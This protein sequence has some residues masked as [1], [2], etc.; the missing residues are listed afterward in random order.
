L[1]KTNIIFGIRPVIEIIK[2]GR[3][4][5]KLLIQKGLKSRNFFDLN[6]LIQK[7]KIPCQ[8]V[9]VE[10]LNNITPKN[11][12]G[13]IGF[14]SEIEYQHIENILPFVYEQGKNPLILILDRITDVRNMGAIARTSE[15]ANVDAIIVP[16]KET[17][18]INADAIKT[19]AGALAKIPVCREDNLIHTFNFLKNSGLQIIACTEKSDVYYNTIDFTIPTAIIIGSEKD[20]ISQKYLRVSDNIVKIPILGKIES[21]NVSVATGI[22]LYEAIRQRAKH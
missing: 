22:I 18:Q 9:P 20:G 1:K 13:V 2:S 19:S 15:C 8:Y 7:Y 5:D 17:A 16:T 14:I 4:I 11:H 3:E 10:K 21:L 12:Q 6:F